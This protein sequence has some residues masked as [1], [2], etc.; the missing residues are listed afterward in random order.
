MNKKKSIPRLPLKLIRWICRE[1][2]LEE[3]EGDME[4]RFEDNVERY[5]LQKARS[6]YYLD[7]IKLLRPA[8]LKRL[9]GDIH[10]NQYG[11]LKHHLLISF[12]SFLRYKGTFLINLFGLSSGLA[13]VLFIYLWVQDEM[14]IN[15]FNEPDSQRH[16]QV[17]HSYPTSGTMYTNEKGFTPNPLYSTLPELF[18]EIDYSFPVKTH[19]SYKGVLSAGDQHLRATYQFAGTGYFKVFPGDFIHGD[20]FSILEDKK[21]IAISKQLAIALFNSTEKAMGKLVELKDESFGGSYEVSG[22]FNPGNTSDRFDILFSYERFKDLDY[23]QWYNGGTQAHLVLKE[24]VDIEEFN[25]KI[26]HFMARVYENS[27][28]LLYAQPYQERYLHGKYKMG[29]PVGGR[30]AYVKLFS[31]IALFVLIIAC[32]NYMNFSTAKATRRIKETGIKKTIG[33][34]RS[35]LIYQFFG[36]SM[37][38]ALLSLLIALI[39][40]VSFLPQFNHITGKTL[41]IFPNQQVVIAFLGITIITGLI[42][43]IYPALHLSAFK[44]AEALKGKLQLNTNGLF[45]RKSLVIFQFAISAILIV[46]VIVIYQ[47]V[48]F[49]QT[50]NLGY[51]KDHII[52]FP[53]EGKLQADFEP[54]LTEIRKIPGIEKASQMYGDLPGRISFSHGYKWE[55]MEEADKKLRFYRIQGGYDLVDLLGIK[56]KD[57]RTFSR[58]Y[59]TDKDA[60]ILNQTAVDMIGLDNPVGRKI[61]NLNPNVPDKEIIGVIENFHFQSLQEEVKPFFF[62]L[63][64]LGNHFLIKVRAGEEAQTIE[65]VKTLYEQFN[66]GYPFEFRFLD[67]NYQAI[68]AAEKRITVLSRYFATIAI[69]ISLLGL[70]ALT[71]FSIQGRNK[72]IAIRK[73]LGSNSGQ[74]VRLLSRDFM[75]LVLI[76]IFLAIP[77]SFLLLRS[78]LDEFAYRI[79]LKPTYFIVGGILMVL[80]AWITILSQTVKSANINVSESLRTND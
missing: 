61:G 54:F 39:I 60:I 32:I 15:R 11:M 76:G 68:Y 26:K 66:E 78:W 18:P 75:L 31:V 52:T 64:N 13:A 24:G 65:K 46:S 58:E 43:G 3:L 62:S 69:V 8:L 14:N 79:E 9:G 7:T 56:L 17:I 50:K 77:I 67:D 25:A 1:C 49:I 19:A 55:G 21:S 36:E 57:G 53:K 40:V 16:V 74:L 10:L 35:N 6:I 4:E 38:L 27:K 37:L 47:Q 34:R 63:S 72:E 80:I 30:I 29:V 42:S 2:Y 5:N 73:I 22:V 20:K 28:D 41:S 44:P 23:M 71:S 12:R 33:A 45:V 51:E 70:L 59:A 48:E